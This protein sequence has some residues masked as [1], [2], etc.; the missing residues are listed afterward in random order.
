[1]NPSLK[2]RG[3]PSGPT[4]E[5]STP[6][7]V[8][9]VQEDGVSI[10]PE[11]GRLSLE[12]VVTVPALTASFA[13]VTISN[14]GVFDSHPGDVYAVELGVDTGVPR[15]ANIGVVGCWC[16]VANSISF[17]FFGTNAGGSQILN[18]TK[19]HSASP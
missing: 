1:M 19:V 15:L 13:D 14:L 16:P 17:R 3:G 5:P 12:A 8:L 2:L 9:T 4:F 10:A 18:V 7:Y 11:L 6:G